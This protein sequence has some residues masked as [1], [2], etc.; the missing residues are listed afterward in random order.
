MQKAP[1]KCKF[2]GYKLKDVDMYARHIES[3]HKDMMIPDM[4]GYQFIYYLT[5]GKTHGNCI[6]CKKE[7]TWNPVTHKY[8]RYCT[9]PNCKKKYRKMFENRMISTRGKVHLLDDPEMQRKMLA[10]RKISGVYKWPDGSTTTYTGSY[11]KAFL[12]LLDTLEWDPNDIMAPSPHTYVYKY[13]GKNHFYI[14]DFYI[15]SLNVEIE[16]KDGGDNPNKHPKIQQIDKEKEKL[17]DEVMK[18]NTQVDYVKIVNK[19]HNTFLKYLMMSKERTFGE[20][21][22]PIVI[23]DDT[24]VT[25]TVTTNE[26]G[27]V[28]FPDNMQIYN[29]SENNDKIRVCKNIARQFN[30]HTYYP[31]YI[32][33]TATSTFVNRHVRQFTKEPYGHVSL[34]FDNSLHNLYSFGYK[35]IGT[36]THGVGAAQESIHK[37]DLKTIYDPKTPY[38]LYC[39]FLNEEQLKRAIDMVTYI[40]SRADNYKFSIRGLVNYTFKTPTTKSDE[41]FCSWFIAYIL[42]CAKDNLLDRHPSLYSPYELTKIKGVYFV[43]GGLI[44]NYNQWRVESITAKILAK[45]IRDNNTEVLEAYTEITNGNFINE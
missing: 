23:C 19:N 20:K 36:E 42:S 12:W 32:L 39:I 26:S 25:Q 40:Y 33:L 43:D 1:K 18:A 7:T 22:Y 2:C 24:Q 31:V 37:E 13:D 15:P 17:K 34:S 45:L 38:G 35:K 4:D 3:K 29:E 6:V 28:L 16:I 27:F 21:H 44:E 8:N 30:G 11:E 10:N 9:D 5:T 14:P 41:F